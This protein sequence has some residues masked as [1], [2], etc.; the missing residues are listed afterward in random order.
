MIWKKGEI[1]DLTDSDSKAAGR[2]EQDHRLQMDEWEGIIGSFLGKKT[3]ENFNKNRF[4]LEDLFSQ[5]GAIPL[6]PLTVPNQMRAS[7]C[8]KK[9]GFVKSRKTVENVRRSFWEAKK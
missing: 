1:L 4:T 5:A 3:H 9:L 7:N 2:I 8:L 6:Q